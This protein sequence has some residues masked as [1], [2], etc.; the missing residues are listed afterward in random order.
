[1]T[2]KDVHVLIHGTCEYVPLHVTRVSADMIK[3]KGL[4]LGDYLGF[5]GWAL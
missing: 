1:M 5:S 2:L 3:F 4:E